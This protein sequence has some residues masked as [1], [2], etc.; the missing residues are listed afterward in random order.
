[1]EGCGGRKWQRLLVQVRVV[2]RLV[3]GYWLGC[4]RPTPR[5]LTGALQLKAVRGTI[6]TFC[7]AAPNT[8]RSLRKA[9]AKV[10]EVVVAS[11]TLVSTSAPMQLLSGHS[12]YPYAS[13][14]AAME[15][16][17]AAPTIAVPQPGYRQF[18]RCPTS[19]CTRSTAPPSPT[20]SIARPSWRPVPP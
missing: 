13:A 12:I 14:V 2:Q 9:P 3:S 18:W 20:S 10:H 11:S 15:V 5:S 6:I 19:S 1:M 7:E 16:A 8:S 4:A 17:T